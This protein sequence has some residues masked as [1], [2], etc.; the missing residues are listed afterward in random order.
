MVPE[1]T[2]AK[3]HPW[4]VQ[5]AENPSKVPFSGW[6]TT[7]LRDARITPPPTGTS[8]VATS[9]SA[10]GLWPPL[11]GSFPP[12]DVVTE[13]SFAVALDDPP[14][15]AAN[16]GRVRPPTAAPARARRRLSAG[17]VTGDAPR[18]RRRSRGDQWW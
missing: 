7:T 17:S 15:H 1:A 3:V 16:R 5:V 13:G 18:G 4:W 6:V 8:A 10:A 14:P 11:P 12:D 9:A 2:L